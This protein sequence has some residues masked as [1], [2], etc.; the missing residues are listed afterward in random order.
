MTK[1]ASIYGFALYGLARDEGLDRQILTQLEILA[2]CFQAEPAFLR[3][4]GAPA[5]SKKERCQI[6]ER[7]LGGQVHLYV[8][9]F[10]KLLTEKSDLGLFPDCCVFYR[11]QYNRDNGILPVSAVTAVPLSDALRAQLISRLTDLT[12]KTIE[13]DC[14]VK[15]DCLGGLRLDFDGIR[16]DGTLRRRLESLHRTLRNCPL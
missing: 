9:N 14:R 5:I 6:L 16:V 4:L 7:T 3:L 15:P 13:L 8:M 10:L 2:A 11:R 1:D 12:G